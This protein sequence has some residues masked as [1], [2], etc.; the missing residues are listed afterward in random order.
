MHSEII[1]PKKKVRG[2]VMVSHEK[3]TKDMPVKR[4]P[5]P[6]TVTLPMRQHIG[7]PCVPTVKVGDTVKIGQVV[8]D[9]DQYV[10]APVHAS[11][12]GKV[13]AVKEVKLA[14]GLVSQAVI[15]ENDGENA[16]L[17]FE[18]PK[19]DSKEDFIK[20][21]RASGLVGL[22]GAGFPTHVKLNVPA[23]KPVDTLI[24]N[25]AECEPYITVDY[26]ECL[27]NSWDVFNGVH[28]VKDMLGVKHVVI[29]VEDNK[30]DAIK[31]LERIAEKQDDKDIVKVMPLKSKYPQGAEKMMVLSATG[32]K[33]PPGKLPADVGCVVLNVASAAFISRYCKSGK[34]LVSRSLTVDGS[35]IENGG[36]R[37]FETVLEMARFANAK[38]DGLY[39]KSLRRLPGRTRKNC[40]RRA[41]DGDGDCGHAPPDF[42]E[43]QRDFGVYQ[44]RYERQ[45]GN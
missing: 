5:A 2:G 14:S 9:T 36:K 25:A 33:V 27:D 8:G 26:R 20:A 41:D 21:V 17:D 1:K 37:L 6:E 7:A 24:I 44:E 12:S 11:V 43:Q 18:P 15:I 42:K 22:G 28:L 23:D 31:I 35:A 16:M 19:I 34:P 40:L 32:R 3:N 39:L 30:P 4:I 29:A 38:L 45:K 13:T 10:S